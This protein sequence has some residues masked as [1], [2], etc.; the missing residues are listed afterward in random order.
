MNPVS[1]QTTTAAQSNIQAAVSA[2]TETAGNV[3]SGIGNNLGP[4]LSRA[5]VA[6]GTAAANH[7]L[8]TQGIP[9]VNDP[10]RLMLTDN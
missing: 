7:F 9:G 8:D 1:E 6:A 4:R 5:A 10:G 2:V 3:I